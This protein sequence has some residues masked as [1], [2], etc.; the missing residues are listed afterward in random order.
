VRRFRD[1]VIDHVE[2]NED[3]EEDDWKN[4]LHGL[5]EAPLIFVFSRHPP[6]HALPVDLG[7]FLFDFLDE[8]S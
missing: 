2:Q 3:N 7:Q 6:G 8:A 4:Q 5:Y 1:A